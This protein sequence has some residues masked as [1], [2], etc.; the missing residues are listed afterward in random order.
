ML[1]FLVIVV[2][3]FLLPRLLPG[4]PVAYLTGFIE[5]E[6]TP[7]QIE[8]YRGVLHLDEPLFVQFAYYLQSLFNGTLGYSYKKEATV[9]SLISGRIG[10]TLQITLPAVII[11]AVIGLFWGMNSGYRRGSVRDK[12]STA[13]QIVLNTMPTFL[14]ALILIIYF[15]F[16][17]RWFPYTGLNSPNVDKGTAAYLFDRL[18]HLFLPVLTLVI[19]ASPSRYLLMRNVVSKVTDEK[20]VL[21]ARERGLSDSVIKYRYLLK[22]VARPFITMVGMSVGACIGGSLIIENLFSINGMGK[23]LSGAIYTLD[24]PL[25]QGIL[26]VT[27]AVMTASIIITDLICILIDPKV[28][29]GEEL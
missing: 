23:L 2:L 5:E 13:F 20:Y 21:Y 7:A 17:N 24:Y 9:S 11:S 10:Y 15:C 28:R 29:L 4:D 6:M 16:K 3:N 26:F 8:Y 22:N 27:S 12:I 14:I 25:M 18:H 1:C 19:A